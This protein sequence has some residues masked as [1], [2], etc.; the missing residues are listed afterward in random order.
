MEVF[1][2]LFEIFGLKI[3]NSLNGEFKNYEKLYKEILN[4]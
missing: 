3:S 4:S 1:N 2:G